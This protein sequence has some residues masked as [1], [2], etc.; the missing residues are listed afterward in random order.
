MWLVAVV[1]RRRVWLVGGIYSTC[2]TITP[3]LQSIPISF[4]SVLVKKKNAKSRFFYFAWGARKWRYYND[5]IH[6]LDWKLAVKHDGGVKLY[7]MRDSVTS[8][9]YSCVC[10]VYCVYGESGSS[11]LIESIDSMIHYGVLLCEIFS[12]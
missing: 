2:I 3:F 7:K 5:V 12:D 1:S 10:N 6:L 11:L 8:A 4:F 9:R